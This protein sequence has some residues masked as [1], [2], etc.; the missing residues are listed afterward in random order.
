MPPEG[1]RTSRRIRGLQCGPRPSR[2]TSL[3]GR[4]RSTAQQYRSPRATPCPSTW[5]RS[6]RGHGVHIRARQ[7]LRRCE[8]ADPTET[9]ETP[10]DSLQHLLRR[11]GGGF[12]VRSTQPQHAR[13]RLSRPDWQPPVVRCPNT[14]SVRRRPL[15]CDLRLMRSPHAC[16]NSRITLVGYDNYSLATWSGNSLTTRPLGLASHLSRTGLEIRRWALYPTRRCLLGLNHPKNPQQ[17]SFKMLPL[18]LSEI[19][20]QISNPLTADTW[21]DLALVRPIRVL[22]RS[23]REAGPP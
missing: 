6:E 11:E 13:S 14:M 12:R 15:R 22:Y 18:L 1:A 21:H 20:P 19:H 10:T 16:N 2:G 9:V 17:L 5:P 7:C 3:P 8:Q 4:R 23:I